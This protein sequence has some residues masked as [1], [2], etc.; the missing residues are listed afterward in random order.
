ME[1]LTCAY[2]LVFLFCSGVVYGI[3]EKVIVIGGDATWQALETRSRIAEVSNISQYP[4]LALSSAGEYSKSLDMFFSFDEG[5]PD[6]FSDRAKHYRVTAINGVSAST[7]RLA[8]AG[9]GAALFSGFPTLES[10]GTGSVVIEPD[11]RGALLSPGN[12]LTDF[13]I[14]FWLYP[15]NMETGEQILLWTSTKDNYILQQIQCT[16]SRN[17]L[18]WIFSN[19]FNDSTTISF[20][21]LSAIVPKTWSHHLLRFDSRT[22]L[23][24]YL[25]NGQLE[26]IVF[27]TDTGHDRGEVYLPVMGSGGKFILGSRFMGMIDELRLYSNFVTDADIYRYPLQ[28]G[29]VETAPID[30]GEQSS[31][32]LKIEAFGGNQQGIYSG[33]GLFRFA[34]DSALE[35]FIRTGD[36]PYYMTEWRRFIPGIELTGTQGRYVQIAAA[37]Y[38]SGDGEATPYLDTLRIHYRPNEPP[39]PPS[40]IM[41]VAKNGAVDLS[42]RQSSAKDTTGYIVYYGT[43]RGEYFGVDANQG[44]SP[45]DVGN[46]T[47]IHID[48]L[49]NGTLYYF[50][51]VAYDQLDPLH[52]GAFSR[53]VTARPIKDF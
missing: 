40:Q 38:P 15:V 33:N 2:L 23:L 21:S 25:V 6:R 18:Q 29:R 12:I 10:T 20:N 52:A 50:A 45:I 28:G 46:G 47:S 9:A 7:S 51:V 48:G 5:S 3:G 49:K 1:K 19:F 4:V 27:A 31:D 30:L 22:G 14:E 17:R 26:N 39:P 37:F 42:W 16:V 13:S 35:F 32:I 36:T 34:D 24:E 53:E 8:R 41:A 11:N 44:K 43:A